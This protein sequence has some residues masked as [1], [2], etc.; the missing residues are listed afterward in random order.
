MTEGEQLTLSTF[1]RAAVGSVQVI[2]YNNTAGVNIEAITIGEQAWTEVRFT[3]T[4]PD[5]CEQVSV[6]YL[7]VAASDDFYISAFV[8]LQTQNARP[9]NLPSWFTHEGLFEGA[10]Y[11]PQGYTSEVADSY[12]AL[13]RTNGNVTIEPEFLR[14][15]QAVHPMKVHLQGHLNQPIAFTVRRPFSDLTSDAALTHAD[16]EYVVAKAIHNIMQGRR[17]RDLIY[18]KRA[19]R[20]AN[21]LDY[22]RPKTRIRED[23]MV[24][25]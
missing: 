1:V 16:R 12:I 5:D 17:Q 22:G 6:R 7:S 2:L 18:G 13:S 10:Y 9:Y 23:K 11:I 14:S 19:S 20:I 3:E 21:R 4:V 8:T 25:V 24:F 15:D